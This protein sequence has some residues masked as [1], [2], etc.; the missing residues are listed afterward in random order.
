MEEIIKKW[1]LYNAVKYKGKA[2][3]NAVIPKIIAEK[4]EVKKRLNS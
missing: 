3:L 2:N 4:P 1:A